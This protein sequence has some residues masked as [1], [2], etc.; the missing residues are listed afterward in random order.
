M[1]RMEFQ[2]NAPYIESLLHRYGFEKIRRNRNG[3][4]ALCKFH[5]DRRKPSFSIS[6]TGLWYCFGC[7]AKGNLRKLHQL[8]GGDD[9][10]WEESLKML[11]IQLESIESR[12][13]RKRRSCV[14]KSLPKDFQYYSIAAEV[15]DV[16]SDRLEWDTIQ[17][18]GLGQTTGSAWPNAN[19]CI[20]PI[21][22]RSGIVGYHGRALDNKTVPKYYNPSGFDIKEYVFNFDSCKKGEEVIIV[23]GAFNAMSM[24]EKGF[25]NTVATFGTNFRPEQ[26][27]KIFKLSPSSIVLCFDRDPVGT[28]KSRAG[29]KATQKLGEIVGQLVTTY[30]MPLP[31]ERDPNDLSAES[32]RECY[33]RKVLFERVFGESDA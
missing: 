13:E 32:L 14:S 8:M 33:A 11:G 20:I 26:I 3:Y 28:G 24:W 1:I 6:D 7:Q 17:F 27:Q 10:D 21:K 15:P 18:F 9:S 19:R 31:F 5:E 22:Y 30:I 25:K 29:Q 16:I 12:T 23:E 4:T 2:K